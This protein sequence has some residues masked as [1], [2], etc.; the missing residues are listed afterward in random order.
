M[1]PISPG[2][3]CLSG[4]GLFLMSLND[5]G[6]LC[7][8]GFCPLSR[9]ARKLWAPFGQFGCLFEESLMIFRCWG[10]T[11]AMRSNLF[12]FLIVEEYYHRI[13]FILFLN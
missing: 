2:K 9:L 1:G 6:S 7:L 13:H 12:C 11:S 10:F 4:A 3:I 8:A 5:N